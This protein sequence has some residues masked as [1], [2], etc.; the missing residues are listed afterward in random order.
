MGNSFGILPTVAF[1]SYVAK[2]VN[3]PV[4]GYPKST[5]PVLT[6]SAPVQ[7]QEVTDTVRVTG[8]VDDNLA[9][10]QVN[11]QLVLTTP[12][13][14][15]GAFD[16]VVPVPADA[17]VR[18]EAVDLFGNRAVPVEV[19]LS[20]PSV[21]VTDVDVGATHLCAIKGGAVKCLGENWYGELGAGEPPQDSKF[22]QVI[23]LTSGVS[24]VAVNETHSCAIMNGGVNCWGRNNRGQLGNNSIAERVTSPVNVSNI[25]SGATDIVLGSEHSCAIVNGG[26]MCWGAN[27]AGQLG[28]GSFTDSLIPVSVDGL[29][30]G[31]KQVASGRLHSCALLENNTVKCWGYNV[32]GQLSIGN[33]SSKNAPALVPLNDV[34]FVA[35]SGL[36]T[37]FILINGSVMCAGD[38]GMGQ[39]GNGT[40]TNSSLPVSVLN[41]SANITQVD[42]SER[43]ACAIDSNGAVYCWGFEIPVTGLGQ[44]LT[45][46][47]ALSL[48]SNTKMMATGTIIN[49]AIVGPDLKCWGRKFGIGIPTIFPF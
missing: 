46:I 41:L 42:I 25:N 6:V 17:V 33:F 20:L 7:N 30:S 35:A 23:G 26:A 9:Q 13:I 14:F 39:L 22:H 32:Q 19:G 12:S 36:T 10:V 29:E 11:G 27:Y 40:K 28:N 4:P 21:G 2:C 34:K 47:P 31:V 8:Y 48:T 24:K 5:K 15:G 38:N 1:S 45:P 3:S 49:C 44:S 37:C 16:V 43:S 18:V